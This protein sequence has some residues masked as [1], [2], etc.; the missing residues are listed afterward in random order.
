MQVDAV[1]CFFNKSELQSIYISEETYS[2]W[3]EK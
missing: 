3:Q 2:S 1:L